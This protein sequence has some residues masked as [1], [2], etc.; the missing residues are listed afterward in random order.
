MSEWSSFGE[1]FDLAVRRAIVRALSV[2]SEETLP[3][4]QERLTRELSSQVVYLA[5]R[6]QVLGLVAGGEAEINDGPGG[7]YLTPTAYKTPGQ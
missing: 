4:L 2:Y 7:P 1:T 3:E 6:D 5:V